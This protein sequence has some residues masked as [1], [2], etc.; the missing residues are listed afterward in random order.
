MALS[1]GCFIPDKIEE[2]TVEFADGTREVVHFKHLSNTTFERFSLWA[3]S[4]N[5]DVVATANARLLVAGV[6]E[7][8]GRPAL[9]QAQAEL[10]KRSVARKLLAALLEVND[11]GK[12][13]AAGNV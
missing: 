3:N 8:D 12:T 13:T 6:C 4:S 10:L 11:M 5:E 2:R 9:T 1:E 7:P